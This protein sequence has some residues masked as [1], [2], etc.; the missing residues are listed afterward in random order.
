MKKLTELKQSIQKLQTD[1]NDDLD[2]LKRRF[3]QNKGIK[4]EHFTK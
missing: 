1:L 4:R 3:H 2:K